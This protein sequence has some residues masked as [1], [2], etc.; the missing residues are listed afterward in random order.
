MSQ[1][2]Q[3]NESRQATLYRMVLPD[4]EC[5]FGLRSLELLQGSG[6]TVDDRHLST[7][8]QTDAFKAEH[9][10]PTTPQTFIG[11]ARVGGCDELERWLN[12]GSR[13]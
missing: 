5:P 8:E 6:Y 3:N 10:V 13:H 9:G 12:S 2:N 11:D 7:R 1:R 4:H